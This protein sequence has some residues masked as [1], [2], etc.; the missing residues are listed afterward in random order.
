MGCWIKTG[1]TLDQDKEWT[2]QDDAETIGY[3]NYF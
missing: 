1:A 2:C 3:P